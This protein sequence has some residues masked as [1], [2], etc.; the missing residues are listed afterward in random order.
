MTPEKNQ[1]IQT[2]LTG[3]WELAISINEEILKNNP[4]DIETMN[5][6]A[7][8]YT[9]MGNNK[10]AK[11]IYKKVLEIDTFNPIALKSLKKL[12]TD[13]GEGLAQ[14][15]HLG[16]DMFLEEHGKTK[17]LNLVNI[18]QPQILTKLQIGQKV[19]ICIKRSKIFVMDESEQFIGMLPDNVGLRLIKFLNA[20]NTYDA[21][22]KAIEQHNISV[23]IR[24]KKRAAKL[25][26]VP[27]FLYS[28]PA[29]ISIIKPNKKIDHSNRSSKDED[30]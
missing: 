3:N 8:A 20:G 5:R 25:K 6:L 2:A 29:H 27:S 16:N 4:L 9:A 17:V 14:G 19:N 22:V 24:E 26:N 21:Y 13:S 30:A 12:S 15:I 10:K 28:E 23:F 1:A 11:E 7:F 18:A